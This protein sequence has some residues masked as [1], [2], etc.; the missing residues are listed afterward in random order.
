MLKLL[1][2]HV[3]KTGGTSI[4]KVL[5]ARF[6]ERLYHDQDGPA[7]PVS[8]MNLDPDGF[9]RRHHSGS[10]EFL[11]QKD[12]VIGHFWIRKYDPVQADLRATILRHPIERTLSHYF[13][14][15]S[16]VLLDEHLLRSYVIESKLDVLQFAR[17]PMIKWF[18]S[19]RLFRH[20]DMKIFDYIGDYASLNADWAGV[21]QSLGLDSPEVRENEARLHVEDYA[22]RYSEIVNDRDRMASL[23]DIL[24]DDI[25]FYERYVCA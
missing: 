11:K 2:V 14:W 19:K 10:Y 6:G 4:K 18:Y 3:P 22:A 13:F 20:T 1:F 15:M 9:L 25:A 12:A 7:N 16:P 21:M 24:A 17:L 8:P 5:E 23:R